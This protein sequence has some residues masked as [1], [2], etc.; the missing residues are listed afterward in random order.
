MSRGTSFVA[1][2]YDHLLRQMGPHDRAIWPD[3]SGRPQRHQTR[4]A[5]DVQNPLAG[6]QTSHFEQ[7]CLCRFQLILPRTLVVGRGPVPSVS[8]HPPLQSR[9]HRALA[10][11]GR[12]NTDC[13]LGLTQ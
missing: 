2:R 11:A 4:A 10:N 9:V 12:V 13:A 6:S 3:K 5:G 7:G 8:L 1:R